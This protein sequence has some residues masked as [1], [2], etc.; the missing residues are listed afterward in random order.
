MPFREWNP[1]QAWLLPPSLGDLLPHDHPSRFVAEFVDGL[2]LEALGI[3]AVPAAEGNPAY[4]PRL[5]LRCWVYGFMDRTR[6]TRRLEK[7]CQ[8]VIPFIWL[9][10]REKPDYSTFSRFYKANRKAMRKVFKATVG[11]AMRAGLVDFALQALDGTKMPVASNDKA[12]KLEALRKLLKEIETTIETMERECEDIGPG[13]APTTKALEAKRELRERAQEALRQLEVETEGAGKGPEK[14]AYV[15][16]PDARLMKTRHG[17]KEAYNAQALVDS[18][19]QIIVA[20]DVTNDRSDQEQLV[21]LLE[22]EKENTGRYPEKTATDAGYFSGNNLAKGEELTELIMPDPRLRQKD[23]PS[24]WP[25]HKDHFSYD[26]E[27]DVYL[28]PQ[29]NE[30]SFA[31]RT[32]QGKGK[33]SQRQY[34]C[35]DCTDCPVRSKCAK[36]A[37]GRSIKVSCYDAQIQAHS[38][39]MQGEETKKLL[40]QRAPLVEGVFGIIKTQMDAQRF[41]LRGLENV[42]AEWYLLCA[43][44]NLRKLYKQW[45]RDIAVELPMAA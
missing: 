8:E 17:W 31:R 42:R 39:K 41:L 33:P 23:G 28:C 30:L 36:S 40:R 6:T 19:A 2:D 4:H 25:Y 5:L 43:A 3:C 13:K 12:K 24:R 14:T 22:Q 16:D 1:Q 9:A 32:S 27:R 21:P 37:D 15:T 20:G 38:R 45:R 35:Q 29:G 11:R 18:K 26:A 34:Q 7:A 10:G 44:F